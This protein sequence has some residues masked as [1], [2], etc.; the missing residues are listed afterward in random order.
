VPAVGLLTSRLTASAGE[1]VVVAFRGRPLSRSFG[2]AT[3]GVP[4]GLEDLWLEDG[5]LL[6]LSTSCFCDRLGRAYSGPI[7]PDEPIDPWEMFGSDEDLVLRAALR[8][9]NGI[10]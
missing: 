6:R 1:A 5:A 2:E 10:T 9:L 4:T 7:E 8:W 3:A